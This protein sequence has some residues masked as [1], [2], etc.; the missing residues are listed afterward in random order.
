MAG[1]TEREA[2]VTGR[3][4]RHQGS[5]AIAVCDACGEALCLACAVPVRGQVLGPGCLGEDVAQTQPVGLAAEDRIRLAQDAAIAA[6]ALATALPWSGFG[7]GSGPFGAWGFTPRWASV[8]TIAAIAGLVTA[9]WS[10]R[11]GR[12]A[13]PSIDD[14]VRVIASIA[15][16][17]SLLALIAPPA[18]TSRGVGGWLAATAAAAAVA[19]DT[20][21]RRSRP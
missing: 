17:A 1:T 14:A 2:N 11:R 5:R 15:L 9:L 12:R 21:L 8:V 16:G 19:A 13:T 4:A 7:L 20:L 18:F 6:L 3:C 10:R